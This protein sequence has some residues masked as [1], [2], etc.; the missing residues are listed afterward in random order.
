VRTISLKGLILVEG[1]PP[2]DEVTRWKSYDE[3]EDQFEVGEVEEKGWKGVDAGGWVW[4][5]GSEQAG[6]G[7]LWRRVGMGAVTAVL[8]QTDSSVSHNRDGLVLYPMLLT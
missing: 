2:L 3:K 7:P 6:T 8:G 4:E 5:R 1:E